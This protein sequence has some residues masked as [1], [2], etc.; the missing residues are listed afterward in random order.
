MAGYRDMMGVVGL[1][2]DTAGVTVIVLGA[3]LATAHYVA[4]VRRRREDAYDLYRHGLARAILLGL[5]FLIAGDLIRTVVVEPSLRNVYVLGL[6]VLIRTFLSTAL[7]LEVEGRW[8]WQGP[9]TPREE[10]SP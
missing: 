9:P 7:Q 1:A 2:I 5:E 3:V 8:P 6:I 4:H 10:P